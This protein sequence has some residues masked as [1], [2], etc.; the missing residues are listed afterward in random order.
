MSRYCCLCKAVGIPWDKSRRFH[1]FPKN[2]HVKE[3]W[4]TAIGMKSVAKTATLCSDHFSDSCYHPNDDYP[5]DMRLLRTGAVPNQNLQKP[6]SAQASSMRELR[7]I[8]GFQIEKCIE[9]NDEDLA[10]FEQEKLDPDDSC[11]TNIDNLVQSSVNTVCSVVEIPA[12]NELDAQMHLS[13]DMNRK[14][15]A[16]ESIF[17][18]TFYALYRGRRFKPKN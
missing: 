3:T 10:S 6:E 18:S 14:S 8:Q 2:N 7:N 1:K 13:H 4:P 16:E 11:R 5:T 15:T 12:S 9:M 17:T